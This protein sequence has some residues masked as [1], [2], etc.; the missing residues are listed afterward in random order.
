[1]ALNPTLDLGLPTAGTRD[2][3][4]TPQQAAELLAAFSDSTALERAI[5]A[6]AFYAG[7]RRGEERDD[8]QETWLDTVRQRLRID[9]DSFRADIDDRHQEIE[10][11]DFRGRR[12]F[13]AIG[14]FDDDSNPRSGFGWMC[15]LVDAGVLQAAAFRRFRKPLLLL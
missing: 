14:C 12:S 2:R 4:A 10:E 5:W 1:M 11:W 13:A 3:A 15:R 9:L 7:L 6:T 8:P